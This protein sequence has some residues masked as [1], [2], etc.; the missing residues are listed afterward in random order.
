[1]QVKELGL[2]QLSFSVMELLKAGQN[3]FNDIVFIERTRDP[4]HGVKHYTRLSATGDP[5]ALTVNE[6]T[7]YYVVKENESVIFYSFCD[8]ACSMDFCLIT[9]VHN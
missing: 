3:R 9:T 1:M 8:S 5:G 7:G 4:K 6:N 2:M